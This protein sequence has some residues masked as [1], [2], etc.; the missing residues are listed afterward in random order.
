MG[1]ALP[2][3][4]NA[5]PCVPKALTRVP[6]VHRVSTSG[7]GRVI[8]RGSDSEDSD[9]DCDWAE[10]EDARQ[11]ESEP[12][13]SALSRV[14]AGSGIEE[15]TSSMIIIFGWALKALGLKK[16]WYYAGFDRMAR[17]SLARVTT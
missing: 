9:E 6:S 14:F 8:Y 4:P 10:A 5:Q 12:E 13:G 17:R 2:N 3:I 11:A 15:K 16:Q 1:F 7:V